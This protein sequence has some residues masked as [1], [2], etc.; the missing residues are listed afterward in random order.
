MS[1]GG[2]NRAREEGRSDRE[3][4]RKTEREACD[5]LKKVLTHT[6]QSCLQNRKPKKEK[7][8]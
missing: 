3:R 6:G 4:K 5:I 1:G 8:I 2:R 7:R